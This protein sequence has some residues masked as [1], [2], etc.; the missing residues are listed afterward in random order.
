[1]ALSSELGESSEHVSITK[2]AICSATQHQ[3][4][5]KEGERRGEKE[6]GG[7]GG[8]RHEG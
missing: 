3:W 5:A 7:Q 2:L 4:P 6:E 1:M 8:G